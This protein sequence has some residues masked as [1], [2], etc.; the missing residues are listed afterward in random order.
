MN[1]PSTFPILK[2]SAVITK[3]I[4]WWSCLT[5]YVVSLVGLPLLAAVIAWVASFTLKGTGI[6]HTFLGPALQALESLLERLI[7]S[8]VA[9]WT[10]ALMSIPVVYWARAKGW[11]GWGTAMLTGVAVCLISLTLIYGFSFLETLYVM[12]LPSA[13]LGLGFWIT[14]RLIHP[15]AFRAQE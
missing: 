10:G 6:T 15:S 1:R 14:V 11:F 13:L 4:T 8:V 9:S 12:S 7:L 2:T 5:G 3:K